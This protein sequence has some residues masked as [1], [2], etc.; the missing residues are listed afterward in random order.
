MER[1]DYKVDS[2]GM[3]KSWRI[4]KRAFIV[5][6]SL[7]GFAEFRKCRNRLLYTVWFLAAVVETAIPGSDIPALDVSAETAIITLEN[8]LPPNTFGAYVTLGR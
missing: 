8:W 2:V 1:V 6:W 5:A 7:L 4:M 3:I